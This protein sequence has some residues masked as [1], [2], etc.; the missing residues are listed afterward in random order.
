MDSQ[1]SP[2]EQDPAAPDPTPAAPSLRPWSTPRLQYLNG[3]ESNAKIKF[4][5]EITGPFASFG[6]S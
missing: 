1:F 4:S 5:T 2:Q 6:A 3:A